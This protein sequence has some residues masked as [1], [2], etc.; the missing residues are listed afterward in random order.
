MGTSRS[1]EAEGWVAGASVYSGRRDPTWQ[2]PAELG[3]HLEDLW[4]ALPAWS[5]PRP[6]PPRL[7]YR[8]CRLAAPDGRVWTTYRELVSL[9][10]DDRRDDRREFERALVASA[11][12]GM[13]PP[14]TP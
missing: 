13:I 6:R 9:T 2:V 11:P 1:R 7:G 14:V 3:R 8:G 5:G 10:D 4:A 12:A